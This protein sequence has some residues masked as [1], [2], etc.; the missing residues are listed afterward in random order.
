MNLF[1]LFGV[2]LCA[3]FMLVVTKEIRRDGANLLS[4]LVGILFFGAMVVLLRDVV[5]YI[6]TL[7]DTM[8]ERGYVVILL[9]ALG[10]AYLTAITREICRSCGEA[11]ISTYVEAVGKAELILLCLPLLKEI[12]DT[13]LRY[14]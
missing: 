9:K 6:R 2:A 12:T 14:I 13:A 8:T 7:G 10:I 1:S 4:L 5:D 11:T 3:V